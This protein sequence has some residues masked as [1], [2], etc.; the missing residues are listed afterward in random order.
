M[1]LNLA[2]SEYGQGQPIVIL[3]GLF[4]SK[5]NW[6]SVAKELADD[7]HVYGLDLR[8]H[9][10]SPWAEGMTYATLANDVSSFIRH[11]DLAPCTVIG[12]SMGGKTAMML[13]LQEPELVS[14]LVVVDIAPV[15]RET[16]IGSYVKTM[17]DVPLDRC[18]SREDVGNH[19][20]CDISSPSLRQFLM[21]NLKREH[22]AFRWRLNLA[23]LG[24]G[25]T[26]IADFAPPSHGAT[27]LGPS[28]FIIGGASKYVQPQHA[29]T[30]EALFPSANIVTIPNAGHWPHV[31]APE[32]FLKAL[33]DLLKKF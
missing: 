19:L 25:L 32:A 33:R 17:S 30:I 29:N 18:Q 28:S 11:H 22:G 16:D 20:K 31:E 27:Y 7:Y 1:A 15:P 24:E 8:N 4:G 21:Q 13:A 14:H 10:S 3:H 12:H 9:G 6:S 23:A 5:R 2:F 26:D